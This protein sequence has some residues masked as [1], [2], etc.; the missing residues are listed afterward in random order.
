M[1]RPL[2]ILFLIA[3]AGH[4]R[5]VSLSRETGDYRTLERLRPLAVFDVTEAVGA[6]GFVLL[7]LSALL[8]S[9]PF[10][11]NWLPTGTFADL[12]SAG[13]VELFNV[14]VGIEVASALILLL[15]KFLEQALLVRERADG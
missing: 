9:D 15:G 12:L 8:V 6:G 4:A 1:I 11:T 14:A 10:L 5:L 3:D 2:N 7:G 13:T